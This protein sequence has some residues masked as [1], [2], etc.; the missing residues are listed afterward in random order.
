M[1]QNLLSHRFFYLSWVLGSHEALRSDG[2]PIQ[3]G[4]V[5]LD[6][7]VHGISQMVHHVS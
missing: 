5:V 6:V 1:K 7:Q 3:D 4:A 2:H